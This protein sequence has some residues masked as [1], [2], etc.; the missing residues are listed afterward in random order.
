MLTAGDEFGR[1][2]H[3][4]NNAYCQ[5]NELTWLDWPAADQDMIDHVSQLST[6]RKR[7]SVFAETHFF[8]NHGAVEWLSPGGTPMIVADWENGEAQGLTMILRTIDY[9]LKTE[10]RLAV[11]FNRS[12]STLDFHLPQSDKRIWHHLPANKPVEPIRLGARSVTFYIE[13]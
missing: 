1:T 12:H 13:H 10:L 11:L 3:G 9:E 8:A 4:N 6:L 2:Q 7:F 5:D